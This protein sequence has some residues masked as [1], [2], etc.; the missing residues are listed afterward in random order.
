MKKVLLVEDDTALHSLYREALEPHGITLTAVT[1]GKEALEK[2][3][4]LGPDLVILDIMLPGGLNGFDVA[5]RLR[6]DMSTA[7]VPLLV[8]TNLD[9]EKPSADAVGAEYLVKT[10]TSLEGIVEKVTQLLHL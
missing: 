5:N 2:A 4:S 8:L 3:K 10:N 1:T 9:S 6:R 7:S